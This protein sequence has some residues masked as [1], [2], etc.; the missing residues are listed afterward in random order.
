MLAS[1]IAGA[2]QL[3]AQ[4]SAQ[5]RLESRLDARTLAAVERV[6]DSARVVGLP[7]DPLVD[8]ALEGAS[9]RAPGQLIVA[10]LRSLLTDLGRA[11]AALG[12]SS[13]SAELG[14]GTD[15]LRAG[16]TPDALR[17]LRRERPDEGLTVPLGVLSDIVSSGVPVEVATKSVLDLTRAGAADELLVAFRRDVERDIGVGAPPATAAMVR[18]NSA[19]FLL[20]T[21]GTGA[22]G[23]GRGPT[24]LKRQRP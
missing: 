5:A 10:A 7:A 21:D 8:R 23:S 6:L 19:Q 1:M 22:A 20:S 16:V 15:A 4:T 3:G 17:R 13:T 14:A 12:M 18:S 9:K 24:S 2:P 11:R